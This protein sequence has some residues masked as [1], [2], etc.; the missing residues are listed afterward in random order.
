MS[1]VIP[2]FDEMDAAREMA[3]QEELEENARQAFKTLAR[4]LKEEKRKRMEEEMQ[5]NATEVQ[6]QVPNPKRFLVY[7]ESKISTL[8]D[9]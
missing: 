4:I 9:L 8:W 2:G 7:P 3:E 6:V 1:G 5:A